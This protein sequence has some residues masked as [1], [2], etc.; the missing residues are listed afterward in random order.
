MK[1]ATRVGWLGVKVGGMEK[2]QSHIDPRTGKPYPM[3]AGGPDTRRL[4]DSAWAERMGVVW[5]PMA[6]RYFPHLPR[7]V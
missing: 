2:M 3:F 1:R 6:D 4:E 7:T 5:D